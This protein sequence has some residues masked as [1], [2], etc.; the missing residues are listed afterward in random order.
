MIAKAC[1]IDPSGIKPWTVRASFTCLLLSS[2]ADA[3]MY[4]NKATENLRKHPNPSNADRA[5]YEFCK[6]NIL[7]GSGDVQTAILHF[8]RSLELDYDQ[9][10]AELLEKLRKK[11]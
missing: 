3:E 1:E 5:C 2:V 4:L 8:E 7:L 11:I 9:E 10:R 6:A